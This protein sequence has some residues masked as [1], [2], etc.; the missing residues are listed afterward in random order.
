MSVLV[1]PKTARGTHTVTFKE[2]VQVIAPQ[3]RST[4]SSRQTQFEQDSDDFDEETMRELENANVTTRAEREQ[5]MP[6]VGLFD[7]SASRKSVE[8]FPL[9]REN[10]NTG[11][12]GEDTVDLDEITAK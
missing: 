5:R 10:R 4:M 2:E 7:S 11:I 1:T 12:V 9:S 8:L 6:L 3:L